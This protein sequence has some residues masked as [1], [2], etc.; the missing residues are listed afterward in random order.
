M[1]IPILFLTALLAQQGPADLSADDR[2]ADPITVRADV[3]PVESLA[4]RLGE[5][6]EVPL[7]VS[8]RIGQD[9]VILYAKDRPAHEV[10]SVIAEHFG[11]EWRKEGDGYRLVQ[12]SAAQKTEKRLLEEAILKPMLASQEEARKS[13]AEAAKLD[14][15]EAERR[16][17]EIDGELEQLDILDE[18]ETTW[19]TYRTLRREQSALEEKLNPYNLFART[20]F[21]SLSRSQL[22]ELDNRTRI[23]LS[24][25]PTAA[26]R[27]SGNQGRR[28]A[29]NLVTELMRAQ[30]E[31]LE[32]GGQPG[33]PP[34][35][36]VLPMGINRPFAPQEVAAVRVVFKAESGMFGGFMG[37]GDVDAR[38]AVLG[39]QGDLLAN[40]SVS[41]GDSMRWLAY[42]EATA[43]GGAQKPRETPQ[44]QPR[45]RLDQRLQMTSAL[46]E[47][48]VSMAMDD[49][50]AGFRMFAGF[51]KVGST[52]DLLAPIGR[53]YAELANAANFAVIADIYDSHFMDV[54]LEGGP[55]GST[56]AG[57]LDSITARSGAQWSFDDTWVKV[58][59]EDW[60][61]ARAGTVPRK[62]LF[63]A[64]DLSLRQAGMTLDQTAALVSRL[65]D[66]QAESQ[67]FF[68]AL[69][70]FGSMSGFPGDRVSVYA[71]RMWHNLLPHQR[72]ALM[73]GRSLA[74]GGTNLSARSNLAEY[75]YRA[76]ESEFG[77]DMMMSM[78]FEDDSPTEMFGAPSEDEDPARDTEITQLL[79]QGP[80][81]DSLIEL[82][83][84]EKAGVASLLKFGDVEMPTSF[85]VSLFVSMRRMSEDPEMG[86]EMGFVVDRVK[87]ALVQT[88]RFTFRL[89][90]GLDREFGAIG[91]SSNPSVRF[92]PVSALPP[93]ILQKIKEI[94]ERIGSRSPPPRTGD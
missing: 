54:F 30:R 87:P 44:R 13:L 88:Y 2:L 18:S 43:E 82:Q 62:L 31:Y 22:L 53:I 81:A 75:L 49:P 35:D 51:Y 77:A 9:L 89:R 19:E 33:V 86:G 59:T 21:A 36:I 84:S 68:L 76:D 29:Q 7:K 37:G 85:S 23:V 65:T 41:I 61:L 3:E 80:A 83:Y 91:L 11:W 24:T 71:Y 4:K 46:R 63:P 79:P 73:A 32:G 57:I 67:I 20:V 28:A 48:I 78:M 69:G 72:D 6:L 5:Q 14:R 40:E 94:E 60:A 26:Q 90:P 8:P 47:A 74:F 70:P 92:G 17:A 15:R 56:A 50:E 55:A 52:V 10:L 93:E 16:I 45:G 42:I 34:E 58:R 25:R 12:T 39:V 66:R 38:V 27:P 1:T 64:R